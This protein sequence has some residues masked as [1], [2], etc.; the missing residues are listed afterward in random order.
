M[1]RILEGRVVEGHDAI[2]DVLVHG[3]AV[4]EDDL[5]HLREVLAQ[6]LGHLLRDGGE[7]ADVREEHGHH[8]AARAQ[9]HVGAM[10]HDLVE[11]R[12]GK[13]L[14][15]A[16]PLPL[17]ADVIVDD[18]GAVAEDERERDADRLE[19]HVPEGEG[20][21]RR[22]RQGRPDQH[23]CH[24][25]SHDA[26][27]GGQAGG[28]QRRDRHADETHDARN[29][30]D[31]VAADERVDDV[32]VDL[33]SRHVAGGREGCREYVV[34]HHARR[35]DEHDGVPE[36]L[37]RHLAAH[38]TVIGHPRKRPRAPTEVDEDL[39]RTRPRRDRQAPGAGQPV[40]LGVEAHLLG[41][42]EHDAQG[43]AAY[44]GV[45]V[46][47]E[48][49]RRHR[50]RPA[51]D[52][53]KGHVAASL[54]V[55]DVA[56]VLDRLGPSRTEHDVSGPRDRGPQGG[57]VTGA[58]RR[59]LGEQ[60]VDADHEGMARADDVEQPAVQGSREWPGQVQ[61]VERVLV[62]GHDDDG[63]RGSPSPAQLEEPVQGAQ[64]DR[65]ESAQKGQ[66]DHDQGGGA[67]RNEGP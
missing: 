40:N 28:G 22:G 16:P 36:R 64:L 56:D 45:T 1:V 37:R 57:V 66:G 43:R 51:P 58:A 34:E 20:R 15:Q 26:Q 3:T 67:A 11:H 29:G 13:E 2:T 65:V 17:L 18:R 55:L 54:L 32:G 61:F 41:V 59:W 52:H 9:R 33:D 4:A 47:S 53:R 44:V 7:S 5:G 48:V 10:T 39:G 42:A 38:H 63:R 25:R 21:Y 24:E 14:R 50:R 19:P 35:S 23:H 31:A 6:H 46:G 27:P 8:A 49:D 60:D 30:E 12:R 62:D